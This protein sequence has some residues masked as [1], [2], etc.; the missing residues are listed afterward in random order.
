MI[1]VVIVGAG[2][3]GV[4]CA[5]LIT[6]N[7]Q[8]EVHLIDTNQESLSV[9]H[10]TVGGFVTQHLVSDSDLEA[11]LYELDP[12]AVVCATPFQINIR[13]A[14]VCN[15][16]GAH[17]LDFTEDVKVKE[18]VKALNP[19]NSTFVLQTGLA[20]GLISQIGLDLV[21]QLIVDGCEPFSLDLR[22]GALPQNGD[23]ALTWSTAG[24]VNEYM[25]PCETIER[26]VKQVRQPLE[27]HEEH[28]VDCGRT[29]LEAFNTSGGM[30][31]ED[32]YLGLEFVNYKTM[33]Y[34]GHLEL[35]KKELMPFAA[36]GLQRGIE[37]AEQI[38]N[39]TRQ[40]VV[41]LY[42]KAVGAKGNRAHERS[43]YRAFMPAHGLT[44]LELTTAGTGVAVLEVLEKN[45]YKPGIVYGGS[46]GYSLIQNTKVGSL[47]LGEIA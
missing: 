24:L 26:G 13:I 3:V 19:G 7:L 38:F 47:F 15:D 20:P 29:K 8:Y 11:K 32:M 10:E 22:V 34:P 44:A 14:G 2:R 43:Y 5:S 1:K 41:H 25:Q 9:A 36:L 21:E 39:F 23:Y 31:D 12:W 28:L 33:R 16:L 35:I 40:D 45:L 30:G 37:R 6:Q 17:Y 18:A 4:A 46:I 42:A 27:G